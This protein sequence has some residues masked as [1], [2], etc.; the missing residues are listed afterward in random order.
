MAR[1]VASET[2]PSSRSIA[3]GTPSSAC[4]DSFV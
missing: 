1:A 3:S 4:F 2:A